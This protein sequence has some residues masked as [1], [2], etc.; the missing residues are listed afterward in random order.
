MDNRQYATNSIIKGWWKNVNV[1]IWGAE[2]MEMINQGVRI[3]A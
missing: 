1:I 3:E 2:V